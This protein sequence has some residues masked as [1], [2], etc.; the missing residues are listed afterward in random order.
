MVG[1]V[2]CIT[3]KDMQVDENFQELRRD[4]NFE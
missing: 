3:D 1:K 4:V 2:K